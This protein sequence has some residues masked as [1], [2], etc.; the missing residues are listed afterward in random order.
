MPEIYLNQAQRNEQADDSNILNEVI[1]D[2]LKYV[3]FEEVSLDH[4]VGG[5]VHEAEVNAA[6]EH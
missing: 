1:G 2:C 3:P 4:V 5:D 6:F